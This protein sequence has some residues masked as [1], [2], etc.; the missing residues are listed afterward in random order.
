MKRCTRPLIGIVSS[1]FAML[2]ALAIAGTSKNTTAPVELPAENVE[3]RPSTLAGYG[4]ALRQC[5]ICHSADYIAY[6][7]PGM[8]L[9]QWTAEATKMHA[10]Y[11]APITA[12]E[13]KLVGI[14]LTAAY[15]AAASV[16][17]A[18]L[19]LSAPAA[20]AAAAQGEDAQAL[21]SRNGCLGCHAAQQKI[22]GPAY[23]DVAD[24]YRSDSQ[25]LAKLQAS[26]R[27]G[28]V[29]R[30]GSV[31]MPPFAGLSETQLKALAEYVL[32]Q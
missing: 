15:G 19:A 6:Q 4:I 17:A 24:K 20:S 11:G 23:R 13:I 21:L 10:T 8:D 2:G 12:D 27:E 29:G 31:P 1:T 9:A 25:A 3:L 5:G 18:D 7:P 28:G 32:K 14:Y 26:I 16:S 22:V 30:W